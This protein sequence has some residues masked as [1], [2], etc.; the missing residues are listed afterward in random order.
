MRFIQR[1]CWWAVSVCL[2]VA[3]QPVTPQ[4]SATPAP[5]ASP[6]L[7]PSPAATATVPTLEFSGARAYDS[8]VQQ[9]AL[10]PR[11]TGSAANHQLG[12]EVLAELSANGWQT[13]TQ[14][15]T[16]QQTPVRNLIGVKGEGT[17]DVIILGAHYDTRRRADQDAAHPNEP[18]PGANDGASGVAVLLELSRVLRIQK[19]DRQVRLVFFDAEDNGDLDGWDWIV[20]STYYANSLTITPTAVVVIDMIGDAQQDIYLE[21]NSNAQ[22]AGAIWDTAA[23][24]GY[25]DQFIK[26]YKWSMEDDH[27][28]FLMRGWKA[29][30]IIDFDYPPWHTTQDT[31]DK[32]SPDSLER[33]GRTLVA[34]LGSEK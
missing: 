21:R 6:T 11:I 30:D 17:A 5:Q 7:T 23:A 12:D 18:V 29:V 15:F 14:D 22:V 19:P 4:P 25:G 31:P 10:G 33:V 24:L 13:Q 2:M 27:T 20:G 9:V 16:Y 28:P 32:I 34:W 3:C 8:V 26:Q 1:A